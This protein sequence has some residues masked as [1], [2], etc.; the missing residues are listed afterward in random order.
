MGVTSI[1]HA[2]PHYLLETS[3]THVLIDPFAPIA[4]IFPDPFATIAEQEKILATPS[5]NMTIDEFSQRLG[6]YEV[7]DEDNRHLCDIA[8]IAA[9]AHENFLRKP[10]DA[11]RKNGTTH[12]GGHVLPVATIVAAVE[13]ISLNN[14]SFG[15]IALALLHDVLEDTNLKLSHLSSSDDLYE[16]LLAITKPEDKSVSRYDRMRNYVIQLSTRAEI[17]PR[18]MV[19][20]L[21]DNAANCLDDWRDLT[22]QQMNLISMEQQN[23][24]QAKIGWFSRL[25][26]ARR[27]LSDTTDFYMPMFNNYQHLPHFLLWKH[28]YDN[29]QRI[30]AENV[31]PD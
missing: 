12:F 20:K 21:V 3:V 22:I 14:D 27:Y 19:V 30:F 7:S 25:R 5:R 24:E 29:L 9:I 1:T 15:T 31:I 23:Y 8:H 16:N 13:S 11:F 18:V 26:Q 4:G 28:A 2:G 6:S 17:D 10:E